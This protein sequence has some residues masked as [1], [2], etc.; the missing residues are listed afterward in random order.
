VDELLVTEAM[1]DEYE[2]NLMRIVRASREHGVKLAFVTQP[3]L[4]DDGL[5]EEQARYA[6]FGRRADGSYT[7]L[8]SLARGMALYNQRMA[9]VARRE[10][11]PWIDLASRVP[12]ST[13]AFYDDL[14][15]NERGAEIVADVLARELGGLIDVPGRSA[16]EGVAAATTTSADDGTGR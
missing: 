4:W 6:L 16:A 10:G 12:R 9:A 13:E 15:F 1:L 8:G 3:A 5:P 7:S 11:V 2:R 14:H